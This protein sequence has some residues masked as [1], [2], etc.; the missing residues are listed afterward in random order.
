M[1]TFTTK[2]S[3]VNRKWYVVDADGKTLGRLASGIARVLLGKHKPV[4]TPTSTP[5]I[6]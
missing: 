5:A 2:L 4:Y 3:D 6:L 1:K